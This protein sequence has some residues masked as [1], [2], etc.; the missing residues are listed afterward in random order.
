MN[1]LLR[2]MRAV[3][4]A[5]EPLA[6]D[7]VN[8]HFQS[9][10]TSLG[11]I[12]EALR[13]ALAE[14]EL[15]WMTFPCR[16][17]HG[18]PALRYVLAHAPSGEQ[19]EDTMPLLLGQAHMQGMGSA[20]T[21]ARRYCL[22]AVF[23][24]VGD[25]DDDGAAAS[26]PASPPAAEAPRPAGASDAQRKRVHKLLRDKGVTRDELQAIVA[27]WEITL[28][29]GWLDRLT[30]GRGGTASQLIDIL[31]EWESSANVGEAGS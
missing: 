22:C 14:H 21:Y 19:L 13:P 9:R 3:Q 26:S 4:A 27:R 8:P 2:A 18:Q 11:A 29:E 28:G 31:S 16:D 17:E 6:K 12:T 23:N 20:L 7:A 1:D 25:D 30:A 15:V 24:V 10:Y 5:L